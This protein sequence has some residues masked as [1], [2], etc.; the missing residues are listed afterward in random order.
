MPIPPRIIVLC[1]LAAALAS[2]AAAEAESG[3]GSGSGDGDSGSRPTRFLSLQPIQVCD[4]GGFFCADLALFEEATRKIWAQADLDI[5]FLSPNR[6]NASRF[7]TID[8][9]DEF[10]ELSFAGG[11]GAFGRNPS[12]TRTS[13]PLNLWFVDSIFAD[14]EF[15]TLGLGWIDQN[16]ITISDDILDFNNGIGRL[17]TVAHEIG[18]NLGLTHSNF[19]AGDRNN[20]MTEGVLR[21]VPTSLDQITPDGQSL[22]QLTN[23]QINFARDSSLVRATPDQSANPDAVAL[24]GVSSTFQDSFAADGMAIPAR[25]LQLAETPPVV[26]LALLPESRLAPPIQPESQSIPD[27]PGLTGI[28]A[29]LLAGYLWR[30]R[31]QSNSPG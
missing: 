13:G 3:G 2:C 16:G 20:L 12:S 6:L 15:D 19:G 18:H 14:D 29:A 10:A 21:Q 26:Q 9:Q 5:S 8:S 27:G 11:P 30:Q 1:G 7:L 25:P 31:R 28:T 22:D 24:A 4:D 23:S 17:D